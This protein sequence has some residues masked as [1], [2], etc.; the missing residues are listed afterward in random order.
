MLGTILSAPQR[1]AVAPRHSTYIVQLAAVAAIYFVVAKLGLVLASVHPNATPI[2]PATGFALAAFLLFGYRIWPAL[3][4][5]AFLANITTAGSIFTSTAIAAGNTLESVVGSWLINR[6][7]NG[8]K[9]FD[10]PLGVAKFALVSFA[11]STMISATLGVAS[12]SL[13]GY[14]AWSNFASI[15][16]TWWIGD[17]A[18]ALVVTPVIV[19]WATSSVRN[20]QTRKTLELVAVVILSSAVGL[21]A[22]SPLLE[23]TAYRSALAFLVILPLMWG[24]LRGGQRDTATVAFVVSCFAVWGTVLNAGPF[25]QGDLNESFLLLL[26]FMISISVPSLALAA[27]VT[28]RRRHEEQRRR[29]EEQHTLLLGEMS[30]RVKNLFA[31]ASGMVALSARSARTPQEVV[32]S[33]QQRLAALTRAH[34]LTRPGLISSSHHAA[35]TTL[36]ALIQTIFA[37]YVNERAK[38]KDGIIVTGCDWPIGGNAITNVALVLHELATNAAKYGA[39]SAPGGVVHIDC[40]KADGTL[41]IKW[42]ELGGPHVKQ[43]PAG[44]GFGGLLTRRIIQDQF[45]GRLSREW[46]PEGLIVRLSV[47]LDR[48]K[49]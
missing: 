44:E 21:I 34:E 33:V 1:E 42:K 46:E 45:G 27:D 24:A 37:P 4:V 43:E 29:A 20:L 3:F 14:A 30:H 48:L 26:A 10:T 40:S 12:L 18:G 39:L 49:S 13:A 8:V 6:W 35:D 23:Q 19:L 2:W 41:S 28:V 25:A 22:F 9:T 11:P 5:A 32:V 7:S 47:P 17:L 38:G 36:H 16:F 15:W 31:V